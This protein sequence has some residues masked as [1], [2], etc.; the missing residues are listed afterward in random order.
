MQ[1]ITS[2]QTRTVIFYQK[3]P[4]EQ[5]PSF[6]LTSSFVWCPDFVSVPAHRDTR[7][8]ASRDLSARFSNHTYRQVEP[9]KWNSGWAIKPIKRHVR[10]TLAN[11]LPVTERNVKLH[12][13]D[14]CLKRPIRISLRSPLL[15]SGQAVTDTKVKNSGC[16]S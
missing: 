7:Q 13:A 4:P 14:T 2:L 11:L 16:T 12:L 6:K 1:L 3:E 8:W 15:T 10:L 5:T 9:D